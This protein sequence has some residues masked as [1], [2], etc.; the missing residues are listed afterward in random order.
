M[1]HGVV[2]AFKNHELERRRE[3][4]EALIAFG[5]AVFSLHFSTSAV[6]RCIDTQ[7]NS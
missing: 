6:A 4:T 1:A 3:Y 2:A 5:A 7:T